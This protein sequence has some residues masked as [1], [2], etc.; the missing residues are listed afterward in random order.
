MRVAII[1]AGLGG[2]ACARV[3]QLCG[4]PVTVYERERSPDARSQGGT[5]DLHPETGQAALRAAGL[6]EQF[7]AL[8]RPEGQEH[9]VLEPATAG[10]LRHDQPGDGE[11]YAPEI[12]RGQLRTLLLGSLADGA[13]RWGCTASGATPLGDGTARLHMADGTA[14]DFELI[15][16]ADGAWSR[17]RPAL[18]DAVPEYLGTTLVETHLDHVDTQHPAIANLIGNGTMIA[19]SAGKALS[20]QRNSGGHV[21]IY[22]MLD[23]PLEWHAAT[24]VNFQGTDAVR[25]LLLREFDGWHD[26]L[27]SLLRDSDAGFINR[28]LYGLPVG[29]S[30]DHTPGLT[31]LGDAAHLMPPFGIGANLAML[32]GVDLAHALA[33]H[34]ERDTAVRAYENT[35]LPRAAAAARACADLSDTLTTE[36]PM[37]VDAVRRYLNQQL[38][39]P[40][41]SH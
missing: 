36:T 26:S 8:S 38:L 14:E 21:R 40:Q 41:T 11:D 32:D 28:P 6:F 29:H 30:W 4:R 1:G 2:L 33:T 37:D 23:T 19:K 31:L 35:M 27:L 22:A 7:R 15:I 34:S 25:E 39:H 17:I 9:R 24:G 10:V 18:S 13:V 20:A 3:L 12:D 16:G 5:L